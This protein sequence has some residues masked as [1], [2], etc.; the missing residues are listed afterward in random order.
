MKA[1]SGSRS[2]TL[3]SVTLALDGD[4][5]LKLRRGRFT[6]ENV[7]APPVQEDGK[8]HP[9]RDS[10]PEP[11]NTVQELHGSVFTTGANQ[12]VQWLL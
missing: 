9:H 5:W 4:G 6:P 2:R 1:Q 8:S 3:L 12:F 11:S 10:T 7:P